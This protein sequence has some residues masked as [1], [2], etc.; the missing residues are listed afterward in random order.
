MDNL[1]NFDLIIT[2]NKKEI[3]NYLNNS[4]KL[5]SIK[6]MSYK[7]FIDF[8][9]GYVNS[10]ALYYLVKKYN[11]SYEV[12]NMYLNNFLYIDNLYKELNENNLIK[13]EPLFKSSFKRIVLMNI[14]LDPYTMN[15][16]SNYDVIELKNNDQKYTPK[17]YEYKTIEDEVNGVALSILKDIKSVQN[18]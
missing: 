17:L 1:K 18:I 2:D 4:K 7:E 12:A 11:Y 16:L 6:I 14:K 15:K 5:L 9:F 3:L 10:E 8:F 13:T